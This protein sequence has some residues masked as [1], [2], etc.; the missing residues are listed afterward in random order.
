[1]S[2][3]LLI[4]ISFFQDGCREGDLV[5]Y[6]PLASYLVVVLVVLKVGSDMKMTQLIFMTAVLKV[7][8]AISLTE[9]PTIPYVCVCVCVIL[10]LQTV[11]MDTSLASSLKIVSSM[12]V[13]KH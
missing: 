4:Y 8:G 12:Y 3:C 2:Q 10:L 9:S 6:S 5:H 7:M 11:R 1:M 13:C